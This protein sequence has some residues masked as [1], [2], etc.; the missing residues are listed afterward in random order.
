MLRVGS[1]EGFPEIALISELELVHALG[2]GSE[3]SAPGCGE[4]RSPT[5][6]RDN[7]TDSVL[8]GMD[9]DLRDEAERILELFGCGVV[10]RSQRDSVDLIHEFL[11]PIPSWAE[12]FPFLRRCTC[13]FRCQRPLETQQ[14]PKQV[15][16]QQQPKRRS[17]SAPENFHAQER[18]NPDNQRYLLDTHLLL[19]LTQKAERSAVDTSSTLDTDDVGTRSEKLGMLFPSSVTFFS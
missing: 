8:L 18:R 6:R 7:P 2:L 13:A 5:L 9:A 3:D 1:S 16:G 15:S 14:H 19:R 11:H 4:G 10:D 17:S 12:G